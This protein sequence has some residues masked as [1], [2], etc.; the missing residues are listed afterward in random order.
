MLE[1]FGSVFEVGFLLGGYQDLALDHT[2]VDS[3]DFELF[4]ELFGGLD[5]FGGSGIIGFED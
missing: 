4:D 3:F 1:E 2:C 5:V